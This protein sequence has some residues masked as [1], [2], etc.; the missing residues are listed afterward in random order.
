MIQKTFTFLKTHHG[1][2]LAVRDGEQLSVKLAKLVEGGWLD[3][4]Y[5][6]SKARN[7]EEFRHMLASCSDNSLKHHASGHDFSSWVDK[8]FADHDLAA[9]IGAVESKIQRAVDPMQLRQASRELDA[10]IADCIRN[11]EPAEG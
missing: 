1:P 5:A 8:V 7:L 10:V 2:I 9:E 3:E 11:S 4:W 6:M